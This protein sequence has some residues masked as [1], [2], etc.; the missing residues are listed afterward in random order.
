GT[1]VAMG[2]VDSDHA[3]LGTA[4]Q[5]IVRGKPVPVEVVKT[6]FTPQRYYRG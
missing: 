5:A 1:P 2:Y 6:P 3:K 4:L